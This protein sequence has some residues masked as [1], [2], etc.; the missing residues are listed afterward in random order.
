MLQA[1]LVT[2]LNIA[3]M[4]LL[5][6]LVCG[7]SLMGISLMQAAQDSPPPAL[8]P[9][10]NGK[11][12]PQNAGKGTE[13]PVVEE[14][15]LGFVHDFGKLQRG[16]IARHTF[17]L[18]NPSN[19]PLKIVSCR[20]SAG[21]L[22]ARCNKDVILPQEE[23]ELEVGFDTTRFSGP[24]TSTGFLQTD[25]GHSVVTRFRVTADSQE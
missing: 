14:A 23:G 10:G 4:I 5:F 3:L 13:Q 15:P 6:A 9:D 7:V 2:K 24:K 12:D 8:P 17:R 19:V 21:A 1:M 20:T 22:I 11:T 18:F 25:N 16:V